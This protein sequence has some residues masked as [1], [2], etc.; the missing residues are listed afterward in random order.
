MSV[1]AYT[2]NPKQLLRAIKQAIDD[3]VVQTWSYDAD[4]DFTHIPEQWK[5]EAWLRPTIHSDRIVF[6]IINPRGKNITRTI[7]AVYHGRFTEMLL[8]HF[9]EKFERATLSALPTA[10]DRVKARPQ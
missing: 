10:N 6:N 3:N 1:T 5:N 4:G 7:Y 9:D 2:D 8:T